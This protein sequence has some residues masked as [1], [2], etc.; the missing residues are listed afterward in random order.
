MNSPSIILAKVST[1][2]FLQVFKIYVYYDIFVSLEIVDANS[3]F[4]QVILASFVKHLID[5]HYGAPLPGCVI[6]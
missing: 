3:I 6:N 1:L 4:C 2:R 5:I